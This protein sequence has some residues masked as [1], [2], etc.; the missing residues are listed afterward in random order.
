MRRICSVGL[1][2]AFLLGGCF[3]LR[4]PFR[5]ER[6]QQAMELVDKGT[7]LLRA[8]RFQEA[9]A[10]FTVA[11][12]ISPLPQAF[13]GIGCA[14]L[15]LGE[16]EEAERYFWEA[17]RRDPNY[18]YALGNLA[19]LYR[20]AGENETATA[21]LIEVV[22]NMPDDFQVRNNFGVQLAEQSERGRALE[23]LRKARALLD[24]PLVRRNKEIL[25]ALSGD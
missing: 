12:E 17:F 20:R 11:S 3:P 13:D 10:A 25:S 22:S 15:G 4:E 24:H 9:K 8:E 18:W 5:P 6:Y 21:L 23:E 1:A 16:L 14:A 2:A 19:L 7:L